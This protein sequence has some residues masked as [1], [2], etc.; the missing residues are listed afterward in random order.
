MVQVL[1]VSDVWSSR[2]MVGRAVATMVPSIDT[3]RM[4]VQAVAK[5]T[6]RRR[7]GAGAGSIARSRWATSATRPAAELPWSSLDEA[8]DD[9]QVQL[10]V[11]R[12]R[13]AQVLRR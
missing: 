2:V 8:A 11:G 3:M 7:P 12:V 1:Q 13:L 4:A 5:M 10:G 6:N 9:G